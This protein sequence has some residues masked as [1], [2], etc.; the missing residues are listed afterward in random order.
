MWIAG[1][2]I[3]LGWILSVCLHE[4]SH[5]LTAYWGGDTSVKDKGY[6]TFNP[7][8]YT[9]PVTSLF[10]PLLFFLMGGIALPGGAVY[11]NHDK[12][13]SRWWQSAVSLAGPLANFLLVLVL[14]IPFQ[15]GWLLLTEDNWADSWLWASVAFL[16]LLQISAVFLNLLP[17]P[18][19]DGYGIL[20]PWLPASWQRQGNKI[21]RYGFWIILGLFWFVPPFQRFFWEQ[22]FAIARALGIAD[23]WSQFG[24]AIFYDPI[25]RLILVLAFIGGLWYLKKS[26]QI[27]WNNS[28]ASRTCGSCR[29][30]PRTGRVSGVG[31]AGT[32]GFQTWGEAKL[33]KKLLILVKNQ[34]D[35]ANNLIRLE[36]LKNPG[37]SERWY[38]EKLIYDLQRG[39]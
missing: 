24:A 19:L 34:H 6:L 18:P 37:H 14:A 33:R 10:L 5:A 38:L 3:F 11:V 30:T 2:L 13:R 17:I 36:K 8:K 21:G 16:A 23:D 32:G 4:F 29:S 26:G 22:T 15:T 12:L 27:A 7:V 1:V 28:S 20:E 25:T 9:D 39:R 35:I 31:S